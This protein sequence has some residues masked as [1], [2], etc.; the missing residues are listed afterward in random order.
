[1]PCSWEHN[2]ATDCYRSLATSWDLQYMGALKV[3]AYE[4]TE[5]RAAL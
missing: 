3:G 4:D 2:V 5:S 1:V